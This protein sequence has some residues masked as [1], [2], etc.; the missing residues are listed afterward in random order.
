MFGKRKIRGLV[1][2]VSGSFITISERQKNGIYQAANLPSSRRVNCGVAEM[3]K[4]EKATPSNGWVFK[5]V[6]RPTAKCLSYSK[7]KL[8]E[9]STERK[10]NPQN[11]WEQSNFKK[12]TSTARSGIG[13]CPIKLRGF[14]TSSR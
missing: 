11:G 10:A 12:R 8:K 6:G 7:I 3:D 5:L 4:I 13:A 9:F 14:P 1:L 2:G